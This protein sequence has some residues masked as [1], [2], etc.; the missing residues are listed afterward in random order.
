MTY[1]QYIPQF[2]RKEKT[3]YI[4]HTATVSINYTSRVPLFPGVFIAEKG[5]GG[6]ARDET[7]TVDVQAHFE[8]FWNVSLRSVCFIDDTF[9]W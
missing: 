4:N 3:V 5:D 1:M 9:F 2:C 6:E 7:T 8:A